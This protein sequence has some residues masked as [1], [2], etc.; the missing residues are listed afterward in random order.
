MAICRTGNTVNF[1]TFSLTVTPTG[2]YTD[3]RLDFA[4]CQATKS[5]LVGDSFGFTSG[6]YRAAPTPTPGRGFQNFIDK[7]PFSSD[8]NASDVGELTEVRDNLS[9]QSSSTDG[10]ASGGR[11]GFPE[12]TPS[13]G[14][15]TIDKFPFAT[16]TSTGCISGLT[17]CLWQISGHSSTTDGYIAGG[18]SSTTPTNN[19]L[20]FPFAGPTSATDIAEL[21]V[22]TA[23]GA[24]MNSST[25]AYISGAKEGPYP[26]TEC[27]NIRKF[28]FANE[29]TNTDVG[30]LSALRNSAGGASSPENGYSLGGGSGLTGT[31]VIDK[32]PFTSDTNATDVAELTRTL[33]GSSGTASPTS[34][35][36]KGGTGCWPPTLVDF[37]T[38]EKFP[39][40]TESPSTDIGDITCTVRSS[41]SQQV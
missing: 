2:L 27:N 33:I 25:H 26:G 39:F 24:A 41:V 1:G 12:P 17:Q 7:F 13:N 14:V 30:E 37:N 40:A 38:I 15:R 8:T 35:Y 19:I 32:F 16:G 18:F 31:D 9:G 11:T 23:A 20:R 5:P 36:M 4:G 29:S 28:A 3:G 10:Y 22:L 21:A 6:G 34:G